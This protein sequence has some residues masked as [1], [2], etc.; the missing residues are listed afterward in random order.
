[1]TTSILLQRS[2]PIQPNTDLQRKQCEKEGMQKELDLAT[3]KRAVEVRTHGRKTKEE[4]RS[5]KEDISN[6][7]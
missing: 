1:M 2:V 5:K 7:N 4:D 6:Q 3:D